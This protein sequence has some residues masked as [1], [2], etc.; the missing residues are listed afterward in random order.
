MLKS[1]FFANW[2]S[3]YVL[4]PHFIKYYHIMFIIII[5]WLGS[6]RPSGLIF[7]VP[8]LLLSTLAP[9]FLPSS[10]VSLS[11]FIPAA[12]MR[13]CL[14]RHLCLSSP[15]PWMVIPFSWN[16]MI[17]CQKLTNNNN[18]DNNNKV[19]LVKC[20]MAFVYW[21]LNCYLELQQVNFS[22]LSIYHRQLNNSRN[23]WAIL[24]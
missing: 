20:K 13:E 16:E 3:L 24:K 22:L 17:E 15:F 4:F 8:S 12:P 11:Y 21:I 10:S 2:I 18:Y 14:G 1:I 23:S 6:S 7:F 19:L 9:L 5:F